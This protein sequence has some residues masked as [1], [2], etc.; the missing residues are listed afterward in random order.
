[1]SLSE[2]ALVYLLELFVGTT[3]INALVCACPVFVSLFNPLSPLFSIGGP[4][5]LG[6]RK[7][8]HHQMEPGH[9]GLQRPFEKEDRQKFSWCIEN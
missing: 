7:A 6:V 4:G 3:G 8:N 5:D 2:M 1:M 9:L